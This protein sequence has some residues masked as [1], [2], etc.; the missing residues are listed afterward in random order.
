MQHRRA[1]LGSMIA[2]AIAAAGCGQSGPGSHS[3]STWRGRW[4]EV[5]APD[6]V[7]VNSG[8]EQAEVQFG[9][10]R[11]VIREGAITVNGSTRPVGNFS[12]VVIDFNAAPVT[13]TVDGTALFA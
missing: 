1:F 11:I 6:G 4:I 3:Y 13:I 9:D 7:F 10:H 5:R 12:R 2:L 8:Q